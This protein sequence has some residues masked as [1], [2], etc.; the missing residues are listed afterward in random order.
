MGPI[1][2][3]ETLVTN[4]K[5]AVLNIPKNEDLELPNRY[6]QMKNNGRG[7]GVVCGIVATTLFDGHLAGKLRY[8][9]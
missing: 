6:E 2:C 3:P 4:Y 8:M 5:Y 9:I 7:H 1:C